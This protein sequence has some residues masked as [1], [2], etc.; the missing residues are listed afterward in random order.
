M[1]KAKQNLNSLFRTKKRDA[2]GAILIDASGSMDVDN[3]R[4]ARLCNAMP[5]KTIAFYTHTTHTPNGYRGHLFIYAEGGYRTNAI[6]RRLVDGG[7][8]VDF[9]ALNWLLEQEGEKTLISDLEFCGGE[10]AEDDMALELVKNHE[11]IKVIE[12]LDEADE[13][14]KVERI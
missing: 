9:P 10:G 5:A 8:D 11:E 13:Y 2:K 4:L 12:S 3:E 7:N 14:Y 1:I 6:D